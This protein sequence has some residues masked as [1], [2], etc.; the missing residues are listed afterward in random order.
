MKR[1]VGIDLG[2]STSEISILKDGKPVVLANH[3]GETITPSVVG[4]LEDGS[5]I[6]GKEAKDQYLAKPYDTVM[7]IKRAMGKE[8]SIKL[9]GQKYTP[10]ELSSEILKYLKK[11]AEEA[12][13]E[14][15]ERAVITVPAYF[16]NEQRKATILAGELAGLQ[17]ERIINE[18]TAAALAYGI[19]HLQEDAHILVYDLGGGTLDVTLL[20]MFDGVLEVKASSGNNELGGKD[21]D[22]CIINSLADCFESQH[23]IDLREDL[24]AF[25]RLKEEAEQC[26]KV[27][28]QEESYKIS[29]PFISKKEQQPLAL[30]QEMTRDLFE[31]LIREKIYSTKDC[32]DVVLKDS[33]M[34]AAAID[35]VLLVG[36]STR[37]PLVKSFVEEV[38]G[39]EAKT[40]IDPDLAVAEGAAIQ[41]A[42]LNDEL[43]AESDILITDVCPYTLGIEVAQMMG[44][45][46]IG[47]GYS[48]LIPRNTTIPV[49]KSD[50]YTTCADGQSM[51]EISVYQGDCKRASMNK[52]LGN[53]KLMDIPPRAAGEEKI[54]VAFTYDVNGILK[55][56]ADIVSTGTKAS[57]QIETN[58]IEQ[59]RT[60][61]LS[62]ERWVDSPLAKSY[63]RTI[64]KAERWM[65]Q[66]SDEIEMVEELEETLCDLKIAILEHDEEECENY[67]EDVLDFL[68]NFGE[69]LL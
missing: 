32:I 42:I 38:L 37:I 40:L 8:E 34:A 7:E 65:S 52:L 2:T 25:S 22:E 47:D 69:S 60:G 5:I 18:P 50:Y 1:I 53:F 61:N 21:F 29:L 10:S 11:C 45:M 39:Q 9:S 62:L 16:N 43:S 57:I 28:T 44:G 67:E 64:S 41:A 30:E 31:Q 24:Y 13:G 3:L 63:K 4:K 66:N 54:K 56:D 51:V 17:V 46:P 35:L 27:L 6:V 68:E 49:T 48:V 58:N 33:K 23:G 14:R 26:K 19:E 20:E 36:G 59:D 15:V 55:V 12:L